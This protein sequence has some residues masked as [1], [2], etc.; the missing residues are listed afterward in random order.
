MSNHFRKISAVADASSS[1]L[2]K[3]NWAGFRNLTLVSKDESR[4]GGRVVRFRRAYIAV[5]DSSALS[6]VGWVLA[7][8]ISACMICSASLLDKTVTSKERC[9][10]CG[11]I[12]CESCCR[13]SLVAGVVRLGQLVVCTN[14]HNPDSV[15]Y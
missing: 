2:A 13:S 4:I 15:S 11:I 6:A 1:I 3:N 9:H 8:D 5:N 10:A 14:C 12:I 7:T